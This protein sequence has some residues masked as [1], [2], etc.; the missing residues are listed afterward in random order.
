MQTKLD[1]SKRGKKIPASPIRKLAKYSAGVIDSGAD[2]IYLN[3]GQPDILTPPHALEALKNYDEKIISYSPSEGTLSFRKAVAEYYKKSGIDNILPEDIYTTI[4]GS[5]GISM[6]FTVI[7]DTDDEII[8]TEPFFSSYNSFCETLESK[9]ITISSDLNKGFE[10]PDIEEFERKITPKTKA[11]LL[12]N[13]G[14]PAGNLYHKEELQQIAKIVKKHNLYLIV[15]EVYREFVYDDNDSH[16]SVLHL[17]DIRENVIVIDSM[18]KRFSMCGARVGVLVT[19]NK[20]I[21][22]SVGKIGQTR[23]SPP[24]LGQFVSEV[25]LRNTPLTYF[26]ELKNVY[27]ERRDFLV[28]GMQEIEGVICPTP[29]GAFYCMV[30]LPIDDA[31]KYAQWLLT[32][33]RYKNTTVMITPASGFYKDKSLAKKQLRIAYVLEINK[34]KMAIE[35]IKNSLEVYP[36]STLRK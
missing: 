12:C 3:I 21:L 1:I 2:I 29:K 18:S 22:E 23:L 9:L 11:I 14:N 33:F 28:K 4:G 19:K 25:A 13:P 34:L 16:F 30:E 35:I 7:T 24:S 36:G 17:E 6:L 10:L 8:T 31:D 20:S 15:D 27:K 5:E 32:D 26:D